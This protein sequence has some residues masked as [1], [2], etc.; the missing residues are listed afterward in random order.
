MEDRLARAGSFLS[1]ARGRLRF[2]LALILALAF[3]ARAQLADIPC[4]NFRT[5]AQCAADEKARQRERPKALAGQAPEVRAPLGAVFV[6]KLTVEADPEDLAAPEKPR[7]ERF[8]DALK[9]ETVIEFPGNDGTRW[10]CLDPCKRKFNCCV[11]SGDFNLSGKP[12]GR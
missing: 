11:R 1:E 7:W 12:A 6:E 5:E 4:R 3:T 8:S 9:G 10:M 2:I